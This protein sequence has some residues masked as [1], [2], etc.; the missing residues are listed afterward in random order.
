MIKLVSA[1]R[2][3]RAIT[4]PWGTIQMTSRFCLAA[5]AAMLLTLAAC[6]K[7]AAPVDTAKEEAA[8]NAQIDALNAAAKAKDAGKLVAF[9]ATE[10]HSYGGG[11]PDV[12]SKDDDLK[13]NT[14]M[15]ADPAFAMTLK[16]EH[17]EIA[18]SGDLAIQTGSSENTGTNPATKAVE[19]STAHWVAGWRKG[20]DGGWKLAAV[21]I[22]S[23]PPTAPADGRPAGSPVGK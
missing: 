4:G 20:S 10:F 18:K 14:A 11:G 7:A 5:G 9:D 2:L 23:P 22:G 15:V 3:A 19:H 8:I 1:A 17:L 6:Q 21:A 13:A 12:N 16:A